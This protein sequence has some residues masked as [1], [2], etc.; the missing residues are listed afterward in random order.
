MKLTRKKIILAAL[1]LV[2]A[3][4]IG[5]Y[6]FIP[7]SKGQSHQGTAAAA[8]HKADGTEDHEKRHND[9][10]GG[11]GLGTHKVR[12]ENTVHNTVDGR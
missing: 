7:G 10:D 4:L 9:I 6:F 1:P 3:A 5:A 2:A 8:G 12:D 11:E